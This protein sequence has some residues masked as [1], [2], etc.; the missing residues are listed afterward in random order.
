MRTRDEAARIQVS[1]YEWDGSQYLRTVAQQVY[2]IN[3][4]ECGTRDE[5]QAAAKGALEANDTDR[6]LVIWQNVWGISWI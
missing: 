3:G 4:V 5:C 2:E 1:R 6:A